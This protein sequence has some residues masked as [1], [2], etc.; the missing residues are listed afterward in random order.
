VYKVAGT[1]V[2]VPA[3]EDTLTPLVEAS[4]L[5][6]LAFRVQEGLLCGFAS[7]IDPLVGVS[8]TGGSIEQQLEPGLTDNGPEWGKVL[9]ERCMV[10]WPLVVWWGPD[11]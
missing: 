2:W 1:V 9:A 4:D 10:A 3:A 8:V 7:F 5:H 11:D 6:Q